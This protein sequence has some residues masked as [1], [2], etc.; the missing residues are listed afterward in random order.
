MRCF[1]SL[2]LCLGVNFQTTRLFSQSGWLYKVKNKKKYYSL[3]ILYFLC[4]CKRGEFMMICIF[5]YS[6]LEGHSFPAL[7]TW[8]LKYEYVH[9]CIVTVYR[10]LCGIFG[11]STIEDLGE[12]ASTITASMTT[13][14]KLS[15]SPRNCSEMSCFL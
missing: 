14:M 4:L 13:R 11:D 6:S 5:K 15:C 2:T 3:L 7:R 10:S 8:C 9:L 1:Y 12:Q